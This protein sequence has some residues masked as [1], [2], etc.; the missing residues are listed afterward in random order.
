MPLE[1]SE[2]PAPEFVRR[3]ERRARWQ[4]PGVRAALAAVALLLAGALALQAGNHFR[5]YV[6]V[7]WPALRTA[8]TE[9]CALAGCTLEAPRR[10]DDIA[11]DSTALA[12]TPGSDAFLLSVTLRSRG[13]VPV[14]VPSVDLSLTDAQR[15]ARRTQGPRA[16]RIQSGAAGLAARRRSGPAALLAARGAGVTGYTVEIFYP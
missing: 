3:A 11:V 9:W 7:R 14:A 15:P 6:A 16:A 13:S 12:R 8:L 2:Q 4:R 5:D 10:I 1:S